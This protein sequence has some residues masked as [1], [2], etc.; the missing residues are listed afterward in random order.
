MPPSC[1]LHV[2]VD[3]FFAQVEKIINPR[4][5]GRPVAVG[6]G[7]VASSCYLARRKYGISTAMTLSEARRRCPQL[8]ILRGNQKIY[9]SFTDRLWRIC[10][11]FS[12]QVETFLDEAYCDLSGTGLLYENYEHAGH[13]L[14]RR[15]KR[16]LDMTVTVGIGT[17]R[18]IAKMAS[19]DVKPDGCLYI[20]PGH[21]LT[22]I[23]A[24]PAGRLPGI[25][26][27]FQRAL[28]DM[29]IKTIGQ[30]RML[31]RDAMTRLFGASGAVLYERCRGIDTQGI[32]EEK[33]PRSISRESSFYCDTADLTAIH[34]MLSYLGERAMR[35]VR[36]L[37]LKV[38]TVRV[39]IGYSDHRH[40]HMSRS[41]ASHT[42]LDEEVF[43]LA[44]H[45]LVKLYTRRATL[46][47]IGITLSNFVSDAGQQQLD[48][49]S[50]YDK[51]KLRRL[52]EAKDRIRQRFGH[53]S[54]VAG[55]A[56]CMLEDYER[57]HYGFILRGACLTK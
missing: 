25:G 33:P 22:Y 10:K 48:L 12:P 11:E 42:V 47:R 35:S 32:A 6:A 34:G 43:E 1:M 26:R 8:V 51:Q 19:K 7:V 36:D 53:A 15:I 54:L 49:F 39:A 45:L 24:K 46:H 18:M 30:L 20:P 37:N 29:N 17:S 5:R 3:A 41:L 16:E 40:E 38:K 27:A 56:L 14:R 44:L 31:G 4:L 52:H 13:A 28:E 57:D 2:D 55:R 9:Q 21:E 23:S 50:R